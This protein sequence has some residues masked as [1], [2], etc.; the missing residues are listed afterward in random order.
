MLCFKAFS[1]L[2]LQCFSTCK[3]ILHDYGL[4]NIIV[5]I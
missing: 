2:C 4:A 1:Y 5:Y 3:H